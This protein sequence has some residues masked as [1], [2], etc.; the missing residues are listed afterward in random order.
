[1][2]KIINFNKWKSFIGNTSIF[3]EEELKY[4]HYKNN[5]KIIIKFLH[6]FLWW[7]EKY[8]LSKFTKL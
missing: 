4:Q 5:R 6:I 7:M 8:K 3:N 2:K 1:M